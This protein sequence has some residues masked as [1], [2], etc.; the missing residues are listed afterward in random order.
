MMSSNRR[1]CY[2]F[3]RTVV[4]ESRKFSTT[5]IHTTVRRQFD[6]THL[7]LGLKNRRHRHRQSLWMLGS[8]GDRLIS[9]WIE[10]SEMSL[11][12]S[13]LRISRS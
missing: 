9:L 11:L 5:P 3:R 8:I 10:L 1:H 12:V 4:G 2:T 6:G 13:S 7:C